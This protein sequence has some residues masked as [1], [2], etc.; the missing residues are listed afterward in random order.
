VT[1]SIGATTLDQV[2]VAPAKP[3]VLR[4]IPVSSSTWGNAENVEVKFV[5]DK[6]F[7][8]EALSPESHDPRQ[9]GVRVLHAVVVPK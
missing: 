6:T 1:V 3:S 5:V 8:P 4:R 7:V 9:L 2:P